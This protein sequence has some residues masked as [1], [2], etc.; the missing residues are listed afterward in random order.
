[1]RF[2]A[3]AAVASPIIVYRL[4]LRRAVRSEDQKAIGALA[5]LYCIGVV[6]I[7][8]LRAHRPALTATKANKNPTSYKIGLLGATLRPFCG[9]ARSYVVRPVAPRPAFFLF[10]RHKRNVMVMSDGSFALYIPIRIRSTT[11]VVIACSLS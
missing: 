3:E 2:E 11:G 10:Y 8:R 4:L 1:M 7:H 6:C 9:W 5:I